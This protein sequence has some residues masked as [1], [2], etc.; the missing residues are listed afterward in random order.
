MCLLNPWN[1]AFASVKYISFLSIP[2]YHL[3][4]SQGQ[5]EDPPC[6]LNHSLNAPPVVIS[7]ILGLWWSVRGIEI[8]LGPKPAKYWRAALS[9]KPEDLN[10]AEEHVKLDVHSPRLSHQGRPPLRPTPGLQPS[11]KSWSKGPASHTWAHR[12]CEITNM[13]TKMLSLQWIIC[14]NRWLIDLAD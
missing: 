8:N 2:T 1:Y 7:P 4:I 9:P 12:N 3:Y 5:F 11:E 14:S 13:Y 6:Y 10:S